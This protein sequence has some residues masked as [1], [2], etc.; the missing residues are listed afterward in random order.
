MNHDTWFAVF[1]ILP[2]TT[3]D[4]ADVKRRKGRK[5]ILAEAPLPLAKMQGDN[6]IKCMYREVQLDSTPDM[7][8]LQYYMYRE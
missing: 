2:S 6:M 8:V 1:G 5:P 7:E 4:D 3:A